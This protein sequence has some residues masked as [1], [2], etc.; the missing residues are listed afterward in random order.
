[1][2]FASGSGTNFQAILNAVEAGQIPARVTG[3]IASKRGIRAIERAKNHGVPY[4]VLKEKDFSNSDRYVQA[5]LDQLKTWNAGL[6]VLAGFLKKVP[7]EIIH[8]YEGNILNLHPSLLP[9]YGGK[10]YFGKRVHEAV[11]ENGEPETGVTIHLVNE[12]Y[13]DGPILAQEKVDIRPDD[14]PES[15]AKRIHQVE[16]EL[17]PRVIAEVAERMNI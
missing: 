6:L 17:Y 14:T 9:K 16:Y 3:L 2:V 8:H 5:L 10:G 15:L 4:L 13:D 11:I 12:E 1:M 7:S